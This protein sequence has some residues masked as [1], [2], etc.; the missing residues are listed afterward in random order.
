M[1]FARF[2]LGC[3]AGG[4]VVSLF[5]GI[6]SFVK[7]VGYCGHNA[8]HHDH[9]YANQREFHH[10]LF[11]YHFSLITSIVNPT[12]ARLVQKLGYDLVTTCGLLMTMFPIFSAYGAKASA[13]R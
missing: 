11:T 8:Q 1:Q 7:Q 12:S 5:D 4:T 13:I 6:V 9:S 10:S 2:V 3:R